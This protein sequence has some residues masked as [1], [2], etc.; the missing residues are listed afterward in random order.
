MP[1]NAKR[2]QHMCPILCTSEPLGESLQRE[3][4]LCWLCSQLPIWW[5]CMIPFQ[6][7]TCQIKKI[8]KQFLFI[9][10]SSVMLLIN[11][12]FDSLQSSLKTINFH[13]VRQ[14][15][16]PYDLRSQHLHMT[17]KCLVF[18]KHTN[19]R[20]DKEELHALTTEPSSDDN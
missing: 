15:T 11:A 12:L 16:R 19:R 3:L 1:S 10:K 4:A 9:L 18:S 5:S 2:W 7:R 6:Y 13:W 17:V 20:Q 14:S 8:V